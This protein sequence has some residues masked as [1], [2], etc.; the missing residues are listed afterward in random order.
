[1]QILPR[2]LDQFR[3]KLKAE[4]QRQQREYSKRYTANKKQ[5]MDEKNVKIYVDSKIHKISDGYVAKCTLLEE[6]Q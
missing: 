1:M 2:L 3:F 6:D 4:D 5:T